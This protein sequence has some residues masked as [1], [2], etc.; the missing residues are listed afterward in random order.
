MPLKVQKINH[1]KKSDDIRFM[2][3]FLS[4][5]G[6]LNLHQCPRKILENHLQYHSVMLFISVGYDFII[7]SSADF[8]AN[9][10][11][12][13]NKT[14]PFLASVSIFYTPLK[15]VVFWCFQEV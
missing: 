6:D 13:I 5:Y 15:P 3:Q 11:N 12:T 8:E 1:M 10:D 9:S 4:Y 14:V 7:L 2:I